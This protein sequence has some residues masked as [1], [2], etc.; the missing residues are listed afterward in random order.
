MAHIF[1]CG[2]LP[3]SCDLLGLR[4]NQAPTFSV[5]HTVDPPAFTMASQPLELFLERLQRTV[6]A[7]PSQ[8][9]VGT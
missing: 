7:H 4:H 5:S 2:C 1:P 6:A 8:I 9:A 3:C